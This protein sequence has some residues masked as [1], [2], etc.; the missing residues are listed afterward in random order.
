MTDAEDE[1]KRR[2]LQEEGVPAEPP[3]VAQPTVDHMH[4]AR[5]IEQE[6]GALGDAMEDIER[7]AAMISESPLMPQVLNELAKWRELQLLTHPVNRLATVL[8]NRQASQHVLALLAPTIVFPAATPMQIDLSGEMLNS[9]RRKVELHKENLRK[10]INSEIRQL[11][12]E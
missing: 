5:R 9:A 11:D 6:M 2:Q 4:A 10:I 3:A 8:T 12:Q 1:F 7:T